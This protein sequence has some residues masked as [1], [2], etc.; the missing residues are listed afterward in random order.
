[1][2]PVIKA[3]TFSQR[4]PK[5]ES[6]HVIRERV[7]AWIVTKHTIVSILYMSIHTYIQWTAC[8]LLCIAWTASLVSCSVALPA[9]EYRTMRVALVSIQPAQ[10]TTKHNASNLSTHIRRTG[11]TKLEACLILLNH[12]FIMDFDGFASTVAKFYNEERCSHDTR[13]FQIQRFLSVVLS[14]IPNW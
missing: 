5:Y 2:R 1:M 10:N 9:G 11:W 4:V 7:G 6:V 13:T 3:K 12:L 8:M 14:K